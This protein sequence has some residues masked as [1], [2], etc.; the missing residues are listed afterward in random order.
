MRELLRSWALSE[1][2]NLRQCAGWALG[3]P[4]ALGG[5]S[6]P[7]RMLANAWATCENRRLRHAAVI[8]YGGLLGAWDPSS[9]A[10]VHL[11]RVGD[12][13][14]ELQA[15]ANWS[16][17]GLTSAGRDASRARASA[18][19]LLMTQSE[20]R[21]QRRRVYAILPLIM[22][23]LTAGH[24]LAR[25]SLKALLSDHEATT[26]RS[27]ASLL[28]WAFDS[29]AGFQSARAAIKELLEAMAEGYIEPD[30]TNQIIRAVMRAVADRERPEACA[31][32]LRRSLLAERHRN[33]PLRDAADAVLD[34]FYTR[35]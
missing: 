21:E 29:A 20:L 7:A 28:A 17:A 14:P 4:V 30:E 8:T 31:G 11:W 12:E 34:T 27:L 33:N 19:D 18:I 9:A 16:F 35:V 32:G 26:L 5:Q 3:V 22:R 23:Q 24:D 25:E 2:L 13:I 1:R 10:A 6:A 15:E